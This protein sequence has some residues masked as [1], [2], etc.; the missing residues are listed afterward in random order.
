MRV[1][2]VFQLLLQ[3]LVGVL[4]LLVIQEKLVEHLGPSIGAFLKEGKVLLLI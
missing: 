2:L 4:E 3:L 1:A